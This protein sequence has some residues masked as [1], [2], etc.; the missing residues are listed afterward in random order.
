M[1][2]IMKDYGVANS[3][4]QTKLI[5]RRQWAPPSSSLIATVHCIIAAARVCAASGRQKASEGPGS[6]CVR[7]AV[8][9]HTIRS[10]YSEQ[11]YRYIPVQRCTGTYLLRKDFCVARCRHCVW[12][13]L[14]TYT[15]RRNEATHMA[16]QQAGIYLPFEALLQFH[17][18]L[19]R[20]LTTYL[21]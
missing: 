14:D 10:L 19:R 1:T 7:L 21:R 12:L 15:D 20:C 5:H 6:L 3:D 8:V 9:A 18:A 16:T 17:N 11:V 2:R 4:K 13:P